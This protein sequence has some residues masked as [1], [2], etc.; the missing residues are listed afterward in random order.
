MDAVNIA[1]SLLRYCVRNRPRYFIIRFTS[2]V[3]TSKQQKTLLRQV[4]FQEVDPR[5][6]V[7]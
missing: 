2:N 4:E 3:S 1:A 7:R 6:S 5:L